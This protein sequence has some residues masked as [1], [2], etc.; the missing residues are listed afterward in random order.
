MNYDK[1]TEWN[2]NNT[3]FIGVKLNIRTD[4]DIIQYLE[5]KSPQTEIKRLIRAEIAEKLRK[6]KLNCH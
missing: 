2:R 4:A 1:Q 3:K 5:G 6:E